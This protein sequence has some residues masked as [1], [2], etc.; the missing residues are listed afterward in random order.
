[1]DVFAEIEDLHRFFVEWFTGSLEETQATFSR[2]ENAL[3]DGF[4][5]V[6]PSGQTQD[7]PLLLE[8]LRSAWGTRRPSEFHIW[9]EGL[10]V[11]ELGGG[12]HL[13]LYQEWQ[14]IAGER[15]GRVSSALLR[16]RSEASG[17]GLEWLRV[18]ETWLPA[19]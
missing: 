14:E 16:S 1:M 19:R 10:E 2:V 4:V 11:L 17:G 5:I 13:V 15:K 7:R 8:Q 18:H 6:G 9:I 12:L 3:A